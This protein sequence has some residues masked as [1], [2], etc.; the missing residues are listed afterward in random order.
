M[1]L[2]QMLLFRLGFLSKGGR[3]LLGRLNLKLSLLQ[4]YLLNLLDQLA[5]NFKMIMQHLAVQ[6]G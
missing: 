5:H 2:W 1:L 6:A 4:M 3:M